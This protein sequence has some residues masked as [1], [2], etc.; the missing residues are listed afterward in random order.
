ML[1]GRAKDKFIQIHMTMSN[2]FLM[3]RTPLTSQNHGHTTGPCGE[4]IPYR[5][6]WLVVRPE[7][8]TIRISTK[9]AFFFWPKK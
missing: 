7:V 9:V 5:W 2:M 8:P 3:P 6:G 4:I 1:L